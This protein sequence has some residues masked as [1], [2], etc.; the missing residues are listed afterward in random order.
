ARLEPGDVAHARRV[1]EGGRRARE[2][3]EALREARERALVEAG[4]DLAD[5]A[6]L[7][8]RVRAQEERPEVRARAAGGGVAADHELL[9]LL[10]LD[11]EPASRPTRL[12]RRRVLLR[13][14]ALEA[15]LLRGAIR[16]EP[17]PRQ[18]ARGEDL[19]G[20]RDRGLERG[21]TLGERGGAEVASVDPE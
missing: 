10:D 5:V 4:A 16:G 1:G 20:A 19:V 14:Q 2:R 15:L 11:L 21:A 8:T 6:Q 18:A 13:D 7:R 9:L 3:P 12:V 17:V